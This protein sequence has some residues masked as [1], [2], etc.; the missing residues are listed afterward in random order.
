MTRVGV[1]GAKG[2]MGSEVCRAITAA[3]D[4]ELVAELDLGDDLTRLNDVKCDVV[5]DFTIPES[6]MKNLEF[7]IENG[8]D[9]VVGTTG[10]DESRLLR[11]KQLLDGKSTAVLIAPNF[12]L[13]GVLM[14]HFA[15]MAAPYFE[16]AEI[17]EL[18]HPR[19]VDAPSGTAR[20][21][22]EIIDGA[23]KAAASLPMP[24]A[25]ESSLDGARGAMI[26]GVHIHSIR[27]EGLLAHQE[28]IFGTTGE[29]LTIRHDSLDRKSFMPG[30]L[31]GIR[32]VK[33]RPGLTYGLENLLF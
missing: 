25:T 17:I 30:V 2:R 33:E 5:V 3:E 12:G 15:A 29:T 9:A 23:R 19:K 4:M 6:V 11:L 26:A 10:F 1:L 21:T 18:H 31:L 20:R 22:A 7:L 8:I 32:K 28:V 14:M 24:D 13:G 16:S 27:A